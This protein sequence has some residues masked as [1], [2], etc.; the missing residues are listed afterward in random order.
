MRI[1]AEIPEGLTELDY[2]SRRSNREDRPRADRE[3]D[4]DVAPRLSDHDLQTRRSGTDTLVQGGN[5]RSIRSASR[6]AMAQ[7]DV[8]PSIELTMPMQTDQIDRSRSR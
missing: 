1:R 8:T 6:R 2:V 3:G 5:L 4:C 7:N